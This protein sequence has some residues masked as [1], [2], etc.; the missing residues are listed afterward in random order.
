MIEYKEPFLAHKTNITVVSYLKLLGV[1]LVAFVI[2]KLASLLMLV[3]LALFIAVTLEPLVGWLISKKLPKG[4]AILIVVTAMLTVSIGLFITLINPISAQLNALAVEF[5]HIKQ[6]LLTHFKDHTFLKAPL[7]HLLNPKTTESTDM[8]KNAVSMGGIALEGFSNLIL[9]YIFTIY[10][11]IDGKRAYSWFRDFFSALTREKIDQTVSE[12]SVVVRGYVGGQAVTSILSALYVYGVLS[13]LKVPAA[14]TL[15]VLAGIFD[16]LPILGFFLS[17]IPAMALSLTISPGTA[18]IV[19]G[20]YVLYHGIENYLIVPLVYGNRLRVSSLV[21]LMALLSSSI[22]GG[23][24]GAIAILP[25]VASYP[26][27]ERIWLM[28]YLGRTVIEKHAADEKTT[29]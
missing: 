28:K 18:G 26:I 9:V 1:S 11:L 12:T 19:F 25:V 14:L 29:A 8:M 7:E 20:L 6:D 4:F 16:I 2:F 15:G 22:L 3:L 27:I 13:F 5:P 10:L 23:I 21:V 17:V 24:L